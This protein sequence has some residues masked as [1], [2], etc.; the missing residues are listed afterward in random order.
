M[1]QRSFLVAFL[2]AALGLAGCS[3]DGG[4]SPPEVVATTS[5]IGALVE[6]IAGDRL[7]VKTLMPAGV[8]PHDYEPSPQDVRDIGA[9][10]LVLRNG[11]GLDGFLD[12]VIAGSEAER[13]VTVTEGIALRALA[14]NEHAHEEAD[15][16]EEGEHEHGEFDPHVWQDP[17]NVRV[18]VANIADALA[19][20][21]PDDADAF[22]ERAEAYRARLDEVD[23]EIRALIDSI[24]LEQRKVISNHDSMRYF[25]DRYGLE[26]VGAVVP[27][28]AHEAEPSPQDIAELEDLIRAEGVRAIFVEA[29]MNPRVAEQI[30]ADTGVTI[31]DDLYGDSLGE[32]GSGAETVDGMLL[33]NAR[34]IVEALR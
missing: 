19:A 2:A 28:M 17:A 3:E 9:A 33:H 22:R 15:H 6:E 13:V 10:A 4:D 27:G 11:L 1:W 8:D 16:E 18:M 21:F 5:Q 23:A 31:V 30:G 34:R 14:E 29:T 7:A 12:A 20:A 24:P 26:F 32:P 25:L